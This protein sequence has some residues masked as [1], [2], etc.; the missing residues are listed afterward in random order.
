MGGLPLLDELMANAWPPLVVERRHGWRFRWTS[1]VTRRANSA[2]AVGGDGHI[3]ELMKAAESF[4]ERHAS[5]CLIQV[6][7]ASAP[8]GLG[9]RLEAGGYQPTART[10]VARAATGDVLARTHSGDYEIAVSDHPIDE[11][12]ETYWSVESG[13]RSADGAAVVRDVLVAAPRPKAFVVVRGGDGVAAVGQVVVERGWAGVQCIAT[14]PPHRRE[15][16]ATAVLHTLAEEASRR[17]AGR[18]YL[19]V[20]ADNDPALGLFDR[21]GFRPVHEYSYWT[22]P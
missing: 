3:A 1:G 6:T 9:P 14:R 4:Y 12:F 8:P 21:A 20:M 16:A 7:G 2:L 19:A 11:W 18:M 13:R 5:P 10:L 15:G 22:A 17:N